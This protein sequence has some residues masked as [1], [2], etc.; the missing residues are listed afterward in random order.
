[1][2]AAATDRTY[3]L[4]E[5]IL[6]R[7]ESLPSSWAVAG[8][9]GYDALAEIDRVLD[10]PRCAGVTERARLAAP[11]PRSARLVGH[12]DPQHQACSGRRHPAFGDTPNRS[13]TTAVPPRPRRRRRGRVASRTRWPSCWHA[14]PCTARTCRLAPSTSTRPPRRRAS[15][16][17]TW[18][19]RSRRL[20]PVLSDAQQP[21]ARRFQQTSGMVMAKGVEDTAFYRYSQLGSLTEV[22][23]DPSQF[24]L[25]RRRVPSAQQTPAG[26]LSGFADDTVDARHQ[27]RRG[28]ACPA[29]RTGRAPESVAS[30]PDRA[31]RRGPAGRWLAGAVAVAGSHR[32]MAGKSRAAARLRREGRARGWSIDNMGGARRRRS[33]RRCTLR[34]TP[35]ST[36]RTSPR[37][38]A[39]SS[40]PSP[41]RDG[42]TRCRPSCCS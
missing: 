41:C 9:T 2:L 7:G 8:T 39:S 3:V 22:G 1:M 38:S 25:T 37:W 34:S 23:G 16:V 21:A 24:S 35:C 33:R 31:A 19:T 30:H 6:Q 27:A 13:G 10:R 11:R 28:R 32:C 15:T 40:T 4:V 18:P 12:A 26:Q 36:T 42:R 5:K 14:S 17:P 29:A 20:L